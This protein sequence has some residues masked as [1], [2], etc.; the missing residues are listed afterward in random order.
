MHEVHKHLGFIY[1]LLAV[2]H[3]IG[4]LIRWIVRKEMGTQSATQV[5]I[6]GYISMV[7]MIIV[8]GSMSSYAKKYKSMTFERR[9]KLH[10]CFNLLIAALCFHTQRTMI[11]SLCFV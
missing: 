3:T 11:I 6:S 1:F 4:H 2:L 5:A 8:V 9:F 10:W 7:A